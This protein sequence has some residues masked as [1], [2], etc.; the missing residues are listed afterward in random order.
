MISVEPLSEMEVE[1]ESPAM[2]ELYWIST[3]FEF[4]MKGSDLAIKR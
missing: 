3:V 2:S 1:D 4:A